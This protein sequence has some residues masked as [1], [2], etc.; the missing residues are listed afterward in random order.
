MRTGWA[1]YSSQAT[2]GVV[3]DLREVMGG[4]VGQLVL[5]G[6]SSHVFGGAEPGGI[7]QPVFRVRIIAGLR[8]RRTL[9]SSFVRRRCNPR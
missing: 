6:M 2:A 5:L 7:S 1:L 4:E 8:V 3:D 9:N